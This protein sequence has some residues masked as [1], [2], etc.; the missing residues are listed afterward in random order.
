MLRVYPPLQKTTGLPVGLHFNLKKGGS[1]IL[2][3]ASR[4]WKPLPHFLNIQGWEREMV[5]SLI[6][7]INIKIPTGLVAK[8]Q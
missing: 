3:L 6:F 4:G 5:V 2:P 7:L 8:R 1:G